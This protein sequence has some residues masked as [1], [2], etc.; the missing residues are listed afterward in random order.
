MDAD[1][2]LNDAEVT[3][4]TQMISALEQLGNTHGIATM[5]YEEIGKYCA[6]SLKEITEALNKTDLKE[7]K[8]A[9]YQIYGKALIKAFNSGN[10][11]TLGLAQSF[12]KVAQQSINEYKITYQIPL[13]SASI[14]GIFN[15]TVTSDIVKKAIRRHYDGIASVLHPG[16]NIMQYYTIDGINYRFEELAKVVNGDLKYLIENDDPSTNKYVIPVTNDQ[17]VD[18]QD[19]IIIIDSVSGAKEVV[20]IDSYEKYLKYRNIYIPNKTIYRHTLRPK[21]LKGS[22]TIFEAS[23]YS[24]DGQSGENQIMSVFETPESILLHFIKKLKIKDLKKEV[25]L[26]KSEL[27]SILE[28]NSK[29]KTKCIKLCDEIIKEEKPE[30]TLKKRLEKFLKLLS[31]IPVEGVKYEDILITHSKVIPAQIAMG[32]LYAKQLGL[33]STDSV[34]DIL[35]KGPEFFEKRLYN[36]TDRKNKDEYSYDACL[37]REDGTPLYVKIGQFKG[38]LEKISSR[39]KQVPGEYQNI[40]GQI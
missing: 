28:N 22:D 35:K 20:T 40:D 11:D 34:A 16:F 36:Q 24:K 3:E 8:D 38:D 1:H 31:N 29:L 13:S 10:K 18:F 4:M 32:R 7:K 37:F 26:L 12:I 39:I 25:E 21:N 17:P 30:R 9:L 2:E 6:E 27:K 23:I 14:N 5:V 15:S 19:T 33:K